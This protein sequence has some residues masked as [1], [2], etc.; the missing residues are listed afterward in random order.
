MP[1]VMVTALCYT[2]GIFTHQDTYHG[3]QV[4]LWHSGS[5]SDDQGLLYSSNKKEIL[6]CY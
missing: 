4:Y 2:E 3:L 1:Y 5:V 6:V